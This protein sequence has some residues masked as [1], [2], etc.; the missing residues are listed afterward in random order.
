MVF[1]GNQSKYTISLLESNIKQKIG[2]KH[3]MKSLLIVGPTSFPVD[4]LYL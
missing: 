3:G 1:P 4:C 2:K